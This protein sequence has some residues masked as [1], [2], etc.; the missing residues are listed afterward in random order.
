[1]SRLLPEL[2]LA[3]I[4]GWALWGLVSLV[5]P[6]WL[7]LPAG[8]AA[9]AALVLGLRHRAGIGGPM[10]VLDPIGIVLPLLILHRVALATGLPVP[11]F[12]TGEILLFLVLYFPFLAAA[13]GVLPV[14]L[15]RQGYRPGPV[16]ALALLLCLYGLVSG[17]WVVALIAVC[18][19]LLWLLKI[20]SSNYFDHITHA[21][22]VPV[23]A[24]ALIV[25]VAG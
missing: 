21:A 13:L 12:A 2:S 16:A 9:G 8:F 23:A 17:N 18:S 5:L 11:A 24:V 4:A 1:M 25:R 10:A 14:D 6:L 20:G 19:Q 22:L 15:Y 7:A 3:L